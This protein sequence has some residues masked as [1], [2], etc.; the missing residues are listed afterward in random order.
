MTKTHE[1]LKHPSYKCRSNSLGRRFFSL[2]KKIVRAVLLYKDVRQQAKQVQSDNLPH[3][4]RLSWIPS[5][6]IL[7]FRNLRQEY[8]MGTCSYIFRWPPLLIKS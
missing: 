6:A 2:H 5:I 7:K 4:V 3:F 8:L 1:L